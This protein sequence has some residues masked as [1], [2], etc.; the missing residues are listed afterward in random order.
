[1]K[2]RRFDMFPAGGMLDARLKTGVV[3]L[4]LPLIA[5]NISASERG[6]FAANAAVTQVQAGTTVSIKGIVKDAAGLTVPGVNVVVKGTTQGTVADWDGNFTI[7]APKGSVLVFSYIGFIP[8]EVVVSNQ[9]TMNIV[10][11]EDTQK[12]DEVVVVAYGVRKKGTVSGSVGVIKSDALENA[13]VASFDQALQG[14]ATGLEVLANSGEPSAPATFKIRGVN[15]I[16]AGTTPLFILDGIAVSANDFSAINPNDIENI[17]VLKDASSTSIYGARAAN[18][19]IVITTK[20]G[21]AGEK[22]KINV[23]TQY[24]WSNLAYGNWDQMNTSER[25]TYEEQIGLRVA[26]AYDREALERININWRDVVFNNNA[27]F[28]NYEV[29]ASGASD[30]FNYFVSG[31]Y[32]GQEGVA[33]GSDFKRYSFRTNLEAR[34]T[35]WFKVGTNTAFSYE[36]IEEAEAGSYTTVTPISASRFMLPY[37]S[38]FK[39]DGSIASLSDGS[40]MGTN[41]NPLE[42]SENNPRN[43]SKAKLIASAFMELRPIQDLVIRSVGGLDFLDRRVNMSSNPSYLPNYG[44][45]SVARSFSRYTNLTWTNTANYIKSIN[46]SHNIN[47]LLGQESVIQES[48][49]FSVASRGQTNDKLLTL[50]TG[51]SATSWDDFSA[52]ATYLSVFGRGEYNFENKYYVDLSVRRDGSSKFGRNSRWATFWSVGSM[53]DAKSESFLSDI[54][55]LTN[56]QLTF[57]IGTSGNSSIPNY[58][59]LALIASGAQYDGKPGMGPL[60]RGNEDLTWEKLMTTNVGLKLGFF[61]RLNMG[62]EFYNKKTSDMLMEVPVSYGT[63]FGYKWDNIGAMVNRGVELDFNYDVIRTR[64]FNWNVNA[65]ISYNHNEITELYNGQD[66]YELA[67]TGML[68]KVGHSYGEFFVVRYAGVNPA[69]GDGLWLD[70]NDNVV[71]EYN[72]NDRVLVG[73]SYNSPWQGGF[74]TTLSYKGITLGA[75]FSWVAD[76]YMMNNDRFFDESNGTF[77]MYNQSAK[78]LDRWQKPGD[79]TDIPRHGILTELDSHLLENASFLRLKNLTL[80]YD[81]PASILKKT[82]V[83]ERIRVYGQGQ[84]LLTFTGF[85]GMD[86]ESSQNIYA[87][88]YPLTRQ[89][90][91][92]LEISF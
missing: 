55:W 57:S 20:R 65:N 38:P 14:K 90:S 31:S 45:G 86:P 3:A 46:G 1:M 39:K 61:N 35:N 21:K 36:D 53:W 49:G 42:W 83:I 6:E 19:V 11:E 71:N 69:N 76:R 73:K 40:W 67:N 60:S 47:L 4:A 62:L 70:K 74:G 12:L 25:L 58:D 64:G 23:R 54:N 59:H 22:G 63:G 72:E 16:N 7:D 48:D 27:P 13:P 78:L 9:T 28:S 79:I 66:E 84:N 44:S 10:L 33:I 8:K 29:S 30:K 37:W 81:L 75:Q 5:G 34:V 87:A 88:T 18:G 92:G 89:F 80:S 15:S 43:V 41:Q 2:K 52:S 56:A 85:T 77:T 17:S 32:Y 50:G 82:K 91:L 26:G 24:G 68:L 51:T